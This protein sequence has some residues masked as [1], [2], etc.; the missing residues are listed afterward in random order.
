MTEETPKPAARPRRQPRKP[1]TAPAPQA[2]GENE[3][4]VPGIE[5]TG[6]T[7]RTEE[8]TN[9]QAATPQMPEWQMLV[10]TGALSFDGLITHR[11]PA[12]SAADAYRTAFED[13]DCLKLLLDWKDMA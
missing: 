5:D 3:V 12:S 13:P 9:M 11:R 1:K 4:S 7:K 8:M 2:S 6:V 10:E